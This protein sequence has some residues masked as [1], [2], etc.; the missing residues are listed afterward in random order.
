MHV[1]SQAELFHL[2]IL[3][4]HVKGPTCF[5]DVRTVEGRVY[6]TFVEACIAAGYVGHDGEWRECMAE[7]VLTRMPKVIR[8]GFAVILK[9][10]QPQNTLDL[11]KEFRL[12]LFIIVLVNKLC[13]CPL[14]P[15]QEGHVGRF[16]I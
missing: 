11:W 5:K 10:C 9:A 8:R 7:M 16:L 15:P 14:T 6:P 12:R 4:M 3:L 13:I 1:S 2:R